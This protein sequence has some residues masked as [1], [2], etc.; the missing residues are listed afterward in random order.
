M[1]Q[2]YA[3]NCNKSAAKDKS[4]PTNSYVVTYLNEGNVQY[5]IVICHKRADVFDMY[6][7]K[8]REQLKKIEWTEGRVNAKLWGYKS[9]ESKK[10]K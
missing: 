10:K 3:E 5:D 1:C 4:L 9:K 6:W 7:D 8:Y 2:I